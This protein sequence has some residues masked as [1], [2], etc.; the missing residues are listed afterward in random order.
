MPDNE[1]ARSA[2][3]DID[4]ASRA[5]RVDSGF[6]TGRPGVFAIGNLVHP[7]D[8]ADVAALD[9]VA[10]ADVVVSYLDGKR[11]GPSHLELVAAPPFRWVVPSTVR[12]DDVGTVLH[13]LRL[14]TDRYAALPV[15]VLRQ[16]GRVV[17]HQRIPWPAAP[18]RMFRVP[19][20][21]LRGLDVEAGPVTIGLR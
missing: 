15:V 16:R 17:A 19:A 21:I 13:R 20:G 12:P 2:G 14:W 9:G 6:R 5:P 3:V 11:C 10:V 18:G 4:P 7:V 1:L 8:T